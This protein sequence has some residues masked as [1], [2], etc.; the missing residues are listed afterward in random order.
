MGISVLAITFAVFFTALAVVAASGADDFVEFLR[1]LGVYKGIVQTF[2]YTLIL[3]FV[4]LLSS[5][6]LFTFTV[7][8]MD[9]HY[10]YQARF[11]PVGFAFL[12][13]YSLM[14]VILSTNDT[15]E[16]ASKRIEFSEAKKRAAESARRPPGQ[17]PPTTPSL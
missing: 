5:V 3:L 17:A 1:E 2:R 15:L 14:A 9:R 11:I 6:V 7:I 16:Y 8:S 10:H 12:F 13:V 4:A